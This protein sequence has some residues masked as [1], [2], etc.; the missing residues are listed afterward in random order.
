MCRNIGIKF[1]PWTYMYQL[2]RQPRD[3]NKRVHIWR[4]VIRRHTFAQRQG[5]E[6]L[7]SSVLYCNPVKARRAISALIETGWGTSELMRVDARG[8]VLISVRSRLRVRRRTHV[9]C[10]TCS[11]WSWQNDRQFGLLHDLCKVYAYTG[12]ILT[13]SFRMLKIASRPTSFHINIFPTKE[14]VP[15]VPS[16]HKEMFNKAATVI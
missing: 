1:L 7:S 13:R 6:R 5:K 8:R 3:S 11:K 2:F 10:R 12:H 9:Q 4:K 15:P 14:F 16:N